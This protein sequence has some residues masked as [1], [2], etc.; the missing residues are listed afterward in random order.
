MSNLGSR[1]DYNKTRNPVQDYLNK[2][3]LETN[4][5]AEVVNY[6]STYFASIVYLSHKAVVDGVTWY[7]INPEYSATVPNGLDVWFKKDELEIYKD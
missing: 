5:E 1:N 7:K 6:Q 2:E 4:L 3:A